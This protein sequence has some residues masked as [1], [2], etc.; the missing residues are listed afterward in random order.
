VVKYFSHTYSKIVESELSKRLKLL[1]EERKLP[2]AKLAEEVGLS[3]GFIAMIETGKK[4]VSCDVLI[5][6]AKYFNVSTDYLLGL[7]DGRTRYP[8][9]N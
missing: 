3:A 8:A 9:T 6:F 2:Q 5:I 4:S 1:R 7:T